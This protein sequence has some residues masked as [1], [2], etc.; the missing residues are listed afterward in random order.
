[1]EEVVFS[2]KEKLELS[3]EEDDSCLYFLF[4]GEVE[5]Q[6]NGKIVEVQRSGFLNYLQFFDVSKLR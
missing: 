4:E 3:Q 6:L 1:M 2:R 5:V